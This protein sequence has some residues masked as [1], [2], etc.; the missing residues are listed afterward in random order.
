VKTEVQTVVQDVGKVDTE[1]KNV[2]AGVQEVAEEVGKVNSEI[3]GVKTGVD[4]VS[5]EV[6]NVKSSVGSNLQVIA[7]DIDKVDSDLQGLKESTDAN[8]QGLNEGLGE[9]GS[10]LDKV[11]SDLQG[12]KEAANNDLDNLKDEIE[13]LKYV[14]IDVSAYIKSGLLYYDANEIPIYGLEIG[15]RNN[16]DGVEVFNKF[17]RFTSDRLSFYDQNDIEVAYISDKKLY[18]S[19]VEVL[20][21][22]KIGG[23]KSIVLTNGDVVKKWV[24]GES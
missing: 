20:R 1:L 24:G 7:E 15:Q 5:G 17:A 16:I 9:V 22:L 11:D 18:I 14:I 4:T 13:N 10:G 8:I 6:E 19:D 2:K 23:I 21:S 12:F 3:E